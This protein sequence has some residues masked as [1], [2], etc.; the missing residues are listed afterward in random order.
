[1][2]EELTDPTKVPERTPEMKAVGQY[3]VWCG[4]RWEVKGTGLI[5]P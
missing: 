4:D 2:S 1:M 3:W 5:W